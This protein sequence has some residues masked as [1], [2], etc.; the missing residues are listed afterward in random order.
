MCRG[1]DID[2]MGANSIANWPILYHHMIIYKI[3]I[4]FLIYDLQSK[5]WINTYY[6]HA[7]HPKCKWNEMCKWKDDM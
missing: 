4:A 6:M 5:D 1:D 3:K 2:L 7:D